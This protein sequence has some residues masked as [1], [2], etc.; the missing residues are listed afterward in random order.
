MEALRVRTKS[1]TQCP[2]CSSAKI[3]LFI[4]S[5]D[6]ETNSGEY[7]IYKCFH[8]GIHFTNPIPIE[9]DLPKLY[10]VKTKDSPHNN[11]LVSNLRSF[12]FQH[13]LSKILSKFG[14]SCDVLDFGSGDGFF[15]NECRKNKY[16]NSITATDF[17]ECCPHF[18][19]KHVDEIKVLYFNYANFYNVS[20]KYDVIFLR[21]VFEHIIDPKKFLRRLRSKLKEKGEIVVEVP[22][23]DSIWRIIF[24]RFYFALFLPRHI[25]HFSPETIELVTSDLFNIIKISKTHSPGIGGSLGYMTH[26]SISNTGLIGLLSFPFQILVDKIFKSSSSMVLTLE[27]K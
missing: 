17:Q 19:K 2:L 7:C 4:K 20:R 15:A 24:G 10:S 3:N 18:L 12:H 22:N 16:C 9:E 11:V 8:C 23:F 1:L 25:F 26:T 14:G 13:F 5:Y 27:K 6:F 21:N